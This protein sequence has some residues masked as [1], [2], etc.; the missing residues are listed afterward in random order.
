[1]RTE[2]KSA[3]GRG[4]GRGAGQATAALIAPQSHNGTCNGIQSRRKGESIECRVRTSAALVG[5]ADGDVYE[6][7]AGAGHPSVERPGRSCSLTPRINEHLVGQQRTTRIADAVVRMR[8]GMRMR[9][10]QL[11]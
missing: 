8:M 1:M 5:A 4:K 11:C 2:G 3:G 9:R 10:T 6:A 7:V